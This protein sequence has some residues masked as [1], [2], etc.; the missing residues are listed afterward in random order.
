MIIKTST[1]ELVLL[2]L[3][4]MH[5]LS[6]SW[7]QLNAASFGVSSLHNFTANVTNLMNTVASNLPNQTQDCCSYNHQILDQFCATR[8]PVYMSYGL[9]ILKNCKTEL[10]Y[11]L[12]RV[13][14]R[15]SVQTQIGDTSTVLLMAAC[16]KGFYYGNSW[17]YVTCVP[18]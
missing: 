7:Q 8:T 13:N 5:A 3:H 16:S 10:L 12:F 18:L 2:A 6:F 11:F 9:F 1:F 14:F 4:N 17:L 15:C